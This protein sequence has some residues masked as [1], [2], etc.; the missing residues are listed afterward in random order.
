MSPP[1]MKAPA[2]VLQD[3]SRGEEKQTIWTEKNS[4]Q[5]DAVQELIS[6]LE[7][8]ADWYDDLHSRIERRQTYLEVVNGWAGHADLA[9]EVDAFKATSREIAE[10]M[11]A[12]RVNRRAA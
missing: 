7:F 6:D 3:Q 8:M 12:R 1:N 9:L 2:E 10:R 4:K 11:S 5:F